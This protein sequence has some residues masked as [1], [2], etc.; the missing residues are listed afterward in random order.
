VH[1]GCG[2]AQLET[3]LDIGLL[4]DLTDAR[5]QRDVFLL[6]LLRINQ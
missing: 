5:G 1:F 2:Q 3:V 4:E 6:I